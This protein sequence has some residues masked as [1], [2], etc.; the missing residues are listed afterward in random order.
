M[1]LHEFVRQ[2][3]ATCKTHEHDPETVW[4]HLPQDELQWLSNGDCWE[5]L[6]CCLKIWR[7]YKLTPAHDAILPTISCLTCKHYLDDFCA[8]YEKQIP[9]HFDKS[10]ACKEWML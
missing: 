1:Q 7:G 9:A 8:R 5:C 2:F 3:T 4:R 10:K 6:E